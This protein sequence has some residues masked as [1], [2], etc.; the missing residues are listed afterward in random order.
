MERQCLERFGLF[1][2][3]EKCR[4]DQIPVFTHELI[5]FHVNSY[6]KCEDIVRIDLI[7]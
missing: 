2:K 3:N 7:V 4:K 5:L 6:I 1:F